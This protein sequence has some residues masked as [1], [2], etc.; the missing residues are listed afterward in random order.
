MKIRRYT[1]KWYW[2]LLLF[3]I[4]IIGWLITYFIWDDITNEDYYYWQEE[5]D[6][7]LK[8]NGLN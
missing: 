1:L 2:W 5:M 4:P 7:Y 3:C 6:K 8:D